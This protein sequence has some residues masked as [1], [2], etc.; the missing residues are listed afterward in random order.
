MLLKTNTLAV[1]LASLELSWIKTN[2]LWMMYRSGWVTKTD[3]KVTLAI[4]LKRPYFIDILAATFPSK[5]TQG[6]AKGEWDRWVANTD[7][8]LQWDPDHDPHGIKQNRKTIQLGLRKSY[9]Y[10]FNGGAIERIEDISTFVSEQRKWVEK[11]EFEKL[12]TS[13]NKSFW[14]TQLCVNR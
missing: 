10:G 14:F 7:V 12:L 4:Y 8:R 9:L 11:G 13:I 5:N 3:Q 2:F 6:I 1:T